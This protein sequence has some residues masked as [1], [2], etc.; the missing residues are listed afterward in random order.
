MIGVGSNL[1]VRDGGIAGVTIRLSAKGFGAA[2]REPENRI[3]AGAALPDKRLAAFA[4]EQG[5]PASTSITASPA[6]SA[7][8]SA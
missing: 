7:A 8:R 5:S 4:L 1:L 3:R 6:R 2:T